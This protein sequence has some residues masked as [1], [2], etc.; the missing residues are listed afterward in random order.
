MIYAVIDTNVIVSALIAKNENS[1]VVEIMKKAFAG[2]FKLLINESIF[3]EYREVL[4]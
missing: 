2:E 4:G 1:P 3:A